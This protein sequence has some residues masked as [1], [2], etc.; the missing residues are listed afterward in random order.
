MTPINQIPVPWLEIIPF[1]VLDL[2]DFP[3]ASLPEPLRSWVQSESIATQTPPDLAGLLALAVCSATL[4]KRFDVEIESSNWREPLNLFVAVLMEP[5]NRKSAV[6]ADA[7]KPLRELETELMETG[8]SSIARLRSK[9]RQAESRLRLLEQEAAKGDMKSE[10]AALD[11]AEELAGRVEPAL[12]QLIADDATPEKLAMIMAQQ[13]GRIASMSPEGGVFDLMAGQ[14]SKSG[15]PQFTLY[16]KG[17]AGEDLITD[18]ISR[19]SVRVIRPA[20]TCAYAIQPMIIEG[21]AKNPAFRGRGLL[22]RFLYAYPKSWLG[23]RQV[24]PPPVAE[25][26]REEYRNLIRRLHHAESER[27]LS[28]TGDALLRFRS[29]QQEIEAML[30]DG[31]EME[32]MTDWGAKLAGATLRLAGILH[33]VKQGPVGNIDISTVSSAIGIASYLIPHADAVLNMMHAKEGLSE[34]DARYVLEWIRRRGLREFTRSEAQHHG[35]RRF[36]KAYDIDPALAELIKRGYILPRP[37][38]SC[39]PGRP[40]SQIYEVN[41]AI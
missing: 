3:T 38:E 25:T 23:S 20:M 5:G 24:D 12:P 7:T 15:L 28:L 34:Q 40:A 18:R 10:Q 36:P 21:L 30:A 37:M 32:L 41:P 33:C 4:A 11:L 2:P 35:K 31:G 16:L 27:T 9:Y 6:F 8:K 14:Y 29:W 22:G 17:H 19:A 1:G 39:G 26:S 13:A